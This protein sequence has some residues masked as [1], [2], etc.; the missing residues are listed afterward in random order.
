MGKDSRIQIPC[1]MQGKQNSYYYRKMGETVQIKAGKLILCPG[2]IPRYCY[3]IR[4]GRVFAGIMEKKERERILF[5]FEEDRLFLEQYL[6]TGKRSP[7]FYTAN[8][9]VTAQKISYLELVQAMKTNFSVTL[10]IIQAIT[11]VGEIALNRVVSDMDENAS[12]KICNLLMDMAAIYGEETQ[13]G[14][15]L[16]VKVKQDVIGDLTGLHRVT[17]AREMKRMKEMGLLVWKDGHYRIPD[18][19]KLRQYREENLV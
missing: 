17:V 13:E 1:F 18:M 6:L 3:F 2:E 4:K 10:D 16:E 8:T 9:D 15:H 12:V 5:S 14:I 11:G 7:L 19:E